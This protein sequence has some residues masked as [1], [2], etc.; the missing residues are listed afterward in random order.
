MFRAIMYPNETK[1]NRHA[2]PSPHIKESLCLSSTFHNILSAILLNYHDC[3][4]F[5]FFEG[6]YL[7]LL[8][9]DN[10]QSSL[11]MYFVVATVNAI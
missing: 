9:L 8:H 7:R 5:Y 3:Y 6:E 4:K 10:S 2:H 1:S 11:K